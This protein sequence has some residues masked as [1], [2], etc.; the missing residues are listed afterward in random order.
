MLGGEAAAQDVVGVGHDLD[1]EA[2]EVGVR[3]AGAEEQCL[4]GLQADVVEEHRRDDAG[5]AR[6]VVGDVGVRGVVAAEA[7]RRRPRP[8]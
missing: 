1:A 2:V 6:V 8:R 7:G 5:V 4:A 3:D